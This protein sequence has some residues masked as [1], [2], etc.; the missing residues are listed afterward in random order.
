MSLS[1]NDQL[2]SV[3]GLTISTDFVFPELATVDPS[4][5]TVDVSV[6]QGVVNSQVYNLDETKKYDWDISEDHFAL[7]IQEIGKFLV[8]QGRTI[9]VEVYHDADLSR[10]R[11]FILGTCFGVLIHQRNLLPLH[12]CAIATP[13]GCKIF[14]GPV[15]IGKSTLAAG[16]VKSG[17]KIL[18]DDVSVI[19]IPENRQPLVYPSYPQIKICPDSAD[20]LSIQTDS[21]PSVDVA[22]TKFRYPIRNNYYSKPMVLSSIYFL[23]TTVKSD[24]EAR[25]IKGISKFQKLIANTYRQM[26]MENI[27]LK[28]NHFELCSKLSNIVP[29]YDLNR[30]SESFQIFGLIE[31]LENHF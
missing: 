5:A 31:F 8:L 30:P 15:G 11:L 9:V 18:A 6:K 17:Y 4:F 23:D 22:K 14:A 1:P 27:E 28:Y 3:Y 7:Y 10:V 13:S 12:G 21:L 24:F 26:L 16:F 2:Y 20:K 25:Q 19:S 29:M